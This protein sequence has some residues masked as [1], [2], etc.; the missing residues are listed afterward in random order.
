[1]ILFEL[2]HTLL[3]SPVY[4]IS[5]YDEEGYPIEDDTWEN[6]EDSDSYYDDTD[7]ESEDET[8]WE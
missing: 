3:L 2:L 7:F 5:G 6:E 1:M 8:E 4:A